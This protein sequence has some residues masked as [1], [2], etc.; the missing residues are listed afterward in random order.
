MGPRQ[1]L[2]EPIF[3]RLHIFCQD[4]EAWKRS[5]VAL[6]PQF[7]RKYY[8][9]L[10]I[11]RQPVDDL[12]VALSKSSSSSSA[13]AAAAA[14]S[15][16]GGIVDL[17]PLF[18]RLTLHLTAI[19]F[20]GGSTAGLRDPDNPRERE[21][22]RAFDFA[23]EYVTKRIRLPDFYW[24]IG[25]ARF[26]QACDTAHMFADEIIERLSAE[27]R[28]GGG[29][30]RYVYFDSIAQ[31]APDRAAL[32]AQVVAILTAGRDTTACLLAWTLYVGVGGGGR[33]RPCI[34]PPPPPTPA[35][36]L[37]PLFR[38]QPLQLPARSPF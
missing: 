37:G 11:F 27:R 2:A 29:E 17:Q 14:A 25:G 5:R 21:V 33:G 19:L 22:A 1:K 3:G 20:F 16:G 26:R 30:R 7:L 34:E 4:G 6:V 32:R 8:E 18:F 24:L 10:E 36:L 28:A 31:S 9:D 38:S 13:A 35:P 15:G 23:Q 12:L